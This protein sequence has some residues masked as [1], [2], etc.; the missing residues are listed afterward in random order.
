MKMEYL[1]GAEESFD[2]RYAPK[3]GAGVNVWST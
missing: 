3:Q 2:F 1:R